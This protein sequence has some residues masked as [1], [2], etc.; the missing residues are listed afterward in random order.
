MASGVE[1]IPS[2]FLRRDPMCSGLTPHSG[3]GVEHG[4][5][6]HEAAALDARRPMIAFFAAHSKA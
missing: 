1:G 4:A 6:Y 3:L 2:R 5:G